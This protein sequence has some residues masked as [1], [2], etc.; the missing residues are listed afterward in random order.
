MKALVLV[1]LLTIAGD[2]ATTCYALRQ[3]MEEQWIG[4]KTCRGQVIFNAAVATPV[5]VYALKYPKDKKMKWALGVSIGTR[6]AAITWNLI[7]IGS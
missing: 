6:S 5:A 7:Q 3:G 4:P 1:F 2:V